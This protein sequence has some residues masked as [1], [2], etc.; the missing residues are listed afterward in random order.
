[1]TNFQYAG[2]ELT[3]KYYH[4]SLGRLCIK[5]EA[6]DGP[7]CTLTTNIPDI[8]LNDGEVLIKDWSENEAIVKHLVD[9]GIIIPT[10]REVSSGYVF[11]MVATI[12]SERG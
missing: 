3:L 5:V 4:Y 2:E 8:H 12:R 6:V 1:M 9:L 10:G 11:P 7:Y